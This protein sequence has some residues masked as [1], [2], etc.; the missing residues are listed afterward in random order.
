LAA[1][2][3]GAPGCIVK[4]TTH[5]L[6]LSPDGTVTWTVLEENV[7]S[8]EDDRR[9]RWREER[10]FLEALAADVN[11]PAEGLRRLGAERTLTRLLRSERPFVVYT[12]ARLGRIDRLAEQILAEL[13]VPG[14]V[15]LESRRGRS[16]F[17]LS[18]D[19]SMIDEERPG[20]ETPV[21]ALLE[22]LERY[23]IV[24]VDGRFESGTGFEIGE[25]GAV[26][27]PKV[28][29]ELVEAGGVL[30]FDLTWRTAAK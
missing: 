4:D 8:N 19:L 1:A 28:A 27:T 29:Q 9:K 3:L 21:E 15:R 23:R 10:A 6:Y 25:D 22:D 5:R 2:A 30:T 18:V 12:Q 26:A 13:Q 14:A 17:R 11:P 24:L 16:T 20:P 7:R